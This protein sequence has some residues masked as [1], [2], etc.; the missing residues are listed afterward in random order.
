[1]LNKAEKEEVL[2]LYGFSQEEARSLSQQPRTSAVSRVILFS[3]E[4]QDSF[5]QNEGYEVYND[6]S[7]EIL[8]RIAWETLF[9]ASRVA[10][11][12]SLTGAQKEVGSQIIE[13]FQHMQRGATAVLADVRDMGKKIIGNLMRN[14]PLL[15][16][17]SSFSPFAQAFRGVPA[18]ICGAGPS[19][20]AGLPFLNQIR[21]RSIVMAGG[22]ALNALTHA[23][24]FPHF[25]AA[26]DPDPPSHLFRQQGAVEAPLFYQNRVAHRLLKDCHGARIWVPDNVSY[27]IEEW[28]THQLGIDAPPFEAG[29]NVATFCLHIAVAMGCNPIILT[30]VDLCHR[31]GKTYASGVSMPLGTFT[32]VPLENGKETKADFLLAADWIEEFIESHPE[33]TFINAS[34]GGLQLRGMEPMTLEEV[35]SRLSPLSFDLEGKIISLL[36]GADSSLQITEENVARVLS[37]FKE[38]ITLCLGLL[39]RMV[40]LL[41]KWYPEDPSRKGEFIL[42]EVECEENPLHTWFLQPLWT[43][44]QWTISASVNDEPY[45]GFSHRLQKLLFFQK[46]LLEI[47]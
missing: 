25:A 9:S 11:S 8:K 21:E 2:F 22:S 46:A 28:L 26:L 6:P 18:L 23:S 42:M 10:F 40:A 33:T 47:R 15:P 34:T 16:K 5:F 37:E 39:E 30:G 45:A 38:N 19:L 1:M 41:Q 7:D 44:W 12:P 20:E 43:V 32:S 4:K 27:P 35:E 13:R 31:E 24:I 29:W 3:Q 36:H 14:L 17:A